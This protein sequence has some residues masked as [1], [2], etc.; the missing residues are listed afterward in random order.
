MLPLPRNAGLMTNVSRI[1]MRH[2]S[3]FMERAWGK[4]KVATVPCS[5]Y[6]MACETTDGM[7]RGALPDDVLDHEL[8][9]STEQLRRDLGD[10]CCELALTIRY[11]A[12]VA[13]QARQADNHGCAVMHRHHSRVLSSISEQNIEYSARSPIDITVTACARASHTT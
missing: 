8:A 2:V 13:W 1:M 11:A 4:H 7:E 10:C 9:R 6:Q 12:H 3:P 5:R